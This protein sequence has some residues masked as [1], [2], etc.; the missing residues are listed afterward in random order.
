MRKEASIEDWKSLYEVTTRI[1]QM[2]PWEYLWDMDLIGIQCG[3]EEETVF[4]SI[5]GRGGECYGIAVYE[6]YEAFNQYL[7]LTMQQ[8]LNLSNEYVMFNQKN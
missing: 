5:L 3:K 1:Q 8:R 2:K 4:Y 6:G 7:M